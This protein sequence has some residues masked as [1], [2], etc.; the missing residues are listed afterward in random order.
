MMVWDYKKLLTK[1]LINTGGYSNI[2][3]LKNLLLDVV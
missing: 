1:K 3:N 2:N